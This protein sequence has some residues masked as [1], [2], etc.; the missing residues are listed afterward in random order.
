MGPVDE[1]ADQFDEHAAEQDEH[2]AEQEDGQQT[3]DQQD[4][5]CRW[6]EVVIAVT[7]PV[8][9]ESDEGRGE[10]FDDDRKFVVDPVSSEGET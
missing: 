7:E 2:A 6:L 8:P 1:V 10:R 9:T 5:D 3:D 4:D